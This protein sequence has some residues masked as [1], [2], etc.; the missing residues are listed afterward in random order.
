MNN[1]FD[2]YKKIQIYIKNKKKIKRY[3]DHG[4][5]R[6][7]RFDFDINMNKYVSVMNS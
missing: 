4:N 1:E 5:K 6:L 7:D 3:I 2:L